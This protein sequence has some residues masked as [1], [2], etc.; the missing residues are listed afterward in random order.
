MH[1]KKEIIIEGV[2]SSLCLEYF[3][4]KIS[5]GYKDDDRVLYDLKYMAEF[6][7]TNGTIEYPYLSKDMVLSFTAKRGNEA[8]RTRK[9]R[10]YLI[11]GFARFLDMKGIASYIIPY[12]R[13][14]CDRNF[15]PYIFSEYEIL[16][17]FKA[18]DEFFKHHKENLLY[19][20]LFRILYGCG[21]R[22]EEALAL[23]TQDVDLGRNVLSV[24]HAKNNISRLVPIHPSLSPFLDRY[25]QTLDASQTNLLF[26]N[27]LKKELSHSTAYANFRNVLK[28]AGIQHKGRGKG[29]RL[30]DFRHTFAV[31]TLN[32]L[33]CEEE[34]DLYCF[35]PILSTYMGHENLESTEKYLRLVPA[36][37]TDIKGKM[38][39]LAEMIFPEVVC[40]K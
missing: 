33:S 38:S 24:F 37:Y 8:D 29:P 18:C 34:V 20:L 28:H 12:E 7:D 15:S 36:S 35:L 5:I 25:M 26:P 14:K 10:I 6:L 1:I 17:F 11:R 40:E 3:N 31:H 21:L 27:T 32:H 22:I 9:K 19:S 2:F 16:N 4:F 23:T 30:H 13:S 39:V